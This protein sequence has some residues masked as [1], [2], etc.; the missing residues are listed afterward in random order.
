MVKMAEELRRRKQQ[1]LAKI[2]MGKSV[3]KFGNVTKDK[4]IDGI[5]QCEKGPTWCL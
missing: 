2:F 3:R 4:Q 5:L 1:E